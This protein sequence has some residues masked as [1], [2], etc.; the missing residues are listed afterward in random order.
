MIIKNHSG[1]S[2]TETFLE[3]V[4]NVKQA[5]KE[6]PEL[7]QKE[8]ADIVGLHPVT[9]NKIVKHIRENKGE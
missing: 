3:N 9:V 2:S 8:V 7:T 6:N 5:Y 1:R 4:E